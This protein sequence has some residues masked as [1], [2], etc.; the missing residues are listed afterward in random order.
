MSA[1]IVYSKD[2]LAKCEARKI[3]YNGEFMGACSVSLNISTPSPIGFEIGDWVEYRGERF[4]LNYDPSV[5]K[6][7]SS[8]TYGE[9][10][11]YENVVFNSLSDELTRC[12]FLDVVPNDNQMHYTS[13][14]TFSF[15][16]N[17]I[18]K[19]AE[20]IQT[21]LDRVYTGNKKWTVSNICD[22]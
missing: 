3:E 15:Y 6:E 10:F 21:N 22:N 18:T 9:G 8:N 4:E 12:D 13:L 17:D 2:G 5:V 7:S 16:A 14:P 20:R 11:V 19:L 1:W